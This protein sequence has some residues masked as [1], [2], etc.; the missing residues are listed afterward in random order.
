MIAETLQGIAD[1]ISDL[2]VY[3]GLK[4]SK[5]PEDK[6]HPFGYGKSLYVWT[7]ISTIIMI[8]I[9]S[10]LTFYFGMQRFLHPREI[11]YIYLIYAV[12][13]LSII[14]SGYS[15]SVASRRILDGKKLRNFISIYKKS[16]MMATKTTF[17]LDL[18]GTLAALIGLIALIAYKL[19]GNFKFDG[20]GAM[21]I[22]L[23]LASL[24]I[25]LLISIKDI[26]IGKS[27]SSEVE[28][29]IKKS[30]KSVKN[31]ISVL[32][33]KTMN[34]G[35]NRILT[36][37]EVHVD[38]NLKTKDIEKLIDSIKDSV[39]KDVPE[40]KHIQVEIE[41]PEPKK[42]NKKQKRNNKIKE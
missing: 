20:F 19:T 2:F 3:I 7:L 10:A 37:V 4:I 30:V 38:E 39:M 25:Y 23:T 34:M 8:G 26:L 32:D 28:R 14:T 42:D 16:G 27:A 40:V 29:K 17:V 33:L 31:V 12:L 21:L 15:L 6:K 36:N 9:T 11:S 5:K 13:I 22:A 1:F 35:I 18:I 24:A 41:T